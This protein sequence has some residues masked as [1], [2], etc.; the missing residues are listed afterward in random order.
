MDP[1]T[2]TI[3]QENLRISHENNEMLLKLVKAQKQQ[4][5]LRIIYW[6]L[7]IVVTVASYFFIEPYLGG[8]VGLYTGGAGDT[9]NLSDITKSLSDPQKI[10]DILNSY[11]SLNQ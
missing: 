3:L 7:I 4:K 11:Q 5:T 9:T 8:L 10:K 6:V 2:K 1:E